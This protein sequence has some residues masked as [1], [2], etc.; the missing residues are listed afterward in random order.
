MRIAAVGQERAGDRQQLLLALRHVGRVVV[1]D[2]VVAVGQ[3]PHEMVDVRRL[4]GLD[5]LVLGRVEPA[6]GDVL[7]DRPVEQP[8]VLEDHPEGRA[9]RVAR[10]RPAVDAVDR[11]PAVVDLV[12]AHQQVHEGRLAGPGRT[13]D[14]HRL[15]GL[16]HEVQVLDERHLRQVAE[17][18]VLERDPTRDGRPSTDQLDVAALLALVE[19]LEDP[20]RGGDGGLDDVGDAGGLGDR[21][22]E[23]AR[24]LDER[25][26]VAEAHHAVGDLDAADHAD[27]DVVEVGDER[28][29]RLDRAGHELR[30]VARLVELFVLAVEGLDRLLLAPE[31]LDDRVSGVHLLDVAVERA[32]LGPLRR[33]ML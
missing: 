4:G 11:D 3:G 21:H 23:L 28:H 27:R 25:L 13:D 32:R 18:H 20:L 8:R 33:E 17:R 9:Q 15:A 26:D 2:G 22:R 24:V 19:E 31:R 1:E 30:L 6:V 10:H 16:D 7:A 29:H 14:R 5:D 12:E